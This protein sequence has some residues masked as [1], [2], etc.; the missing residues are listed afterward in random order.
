MWFERAAGAAV[1]IA[2]H[3]AARA[4]LRQS[5]DLTPDSDVLDRASRWQRL[6]DATAYVA[7]MD[8]GATAYQ[9]AA[10][11]SRQVLQHPGAS[12]ER[13]AEARSVH[14]LSITSLGLV[15]IQQLRFKEAVALA[16]A[17]LE[18]IGAAEDLDTA[19]LLY[20]RAWGTTAWAYQPQV[21][22][23][24]ERAMELATK[25]GDRRL[26]LEVRF[27]FTSAAADE[28]TMT[29]ADLAASDLAALE[30]AYEL[31]DWQ[32]VCKLSRS[33]AI[34]LM[35]TDGEASVAALKQASAVAEAHGLTEET[36]W[37]DYVRTE[38]GLVSGDWK[39][40]VAAGQGALD[41]ADRNAYHRVQV[42]TWSALSPIA[43]A[44]GRTDLLERAA[45]WFAAHQAIFPGSPFGSVL[46]GAVD[47]CLARAGLIDPPTLPVEDML[48]AWNETQG[49]PSWHA[50]VEEIAQWW[51]ERNKLDPVRQV[52]D[53]VAAWH[54]HPTTEAS[55]RGAE[56]LL[57][58][59]LLLAEGDEAGSSAQA[60]TA[61]DEF[62]S[63]HAPGG[64][65]SPSGRWRA[66][67]APHRICF[68]RPPPSRGAWG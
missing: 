65:R 4:L 7:D 6:G 52:L 41:L 2:A 62:R 29:R 22:L 42:R 30:T 25:L 19:W 47:V 58:A 35:E 60:A 56:A 39:T 1:E 10:D 5:L 18:E 38:L 53:R 37:G 50:A 33:R 23:D 68:V 31:G 46:H 3:D 55:G 51:L 32:R 54:D 61:L 13:R 20:L 21:K 26:E 57:R 9:S 49:L 43:G 67:A 24:L 45:R 63:C 48:P 44:T 8:E 59:R 28:G 40:G 17:A 27:Q 11:L 15:R 64:S 12:P 14:A 16:N 66:P 36:A 34:L